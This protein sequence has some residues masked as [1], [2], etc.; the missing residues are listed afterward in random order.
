[1]SRKRGRYPKKKEEKGDATLKEEK[2]DATLYCH[3][4]VKKK[5]TLPFI[6]ILLLPHSL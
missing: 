1:M 3:S 5:G 4:S 6:V 2:G